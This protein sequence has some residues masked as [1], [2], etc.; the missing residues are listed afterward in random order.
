MK[1]T[2]VDSCV[3][4]VPTSHYMALDF[5]QHKLVVAQIR[6]DQGLEGLGY[7]LCF[8]GGGAVSSWTAA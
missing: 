2:A 5:P 8:G 6:T 7:S 1:I 3:L 4:A